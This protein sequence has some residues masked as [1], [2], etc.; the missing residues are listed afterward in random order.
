MVKRFTIGLN[1]FFNN[2]SNSG[3]VNYIFNIVAALKTLPEEE[4]PGLVIFY[5]R[6]AP[7]DFLKKIGYPY[8]EY[9]LFNAYPKKPILRKFNNLT[10]R[11]LKKDLYKQL[12]YFNKIDCLYPYFDF[13]DFEFADF[14]KKVHWLVDFNNR[15]FSAHYEDGGLFMLKSQQKLTSSKERVV[16]SSNTLLNELKQ[17]YPHYRCDVKVMRFASSL[18]VLNSRD[19]DLVKNKY[20]IDVPYLMSPNQLWEHKNQALVLDALNVLKQEHPELKFKVFF[21]GSLEVN[22]GKGLYIDLLKSKVAEYQ[23]NEYVV[24]LGVLDRQ[25]QLLL[26]Q[27]ASA[28]LQPSLYEGW[29]T[30]VEE[31]KA[32]NKFIILS[33]LP[34]HREQIGDNVAFFDPF[35]AGDLATKIEAQLKSPAAVLPIDYK[36]NI[37]K[38]GRDILNALAVTAK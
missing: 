1:Y 11:I 10:K 28:L 25:E 6:E 38:Y 21:S 30:L 31:A 12:R 9:V 29:S 13:Q 35:N 33:D 36:E 37:K 2:Q 5:G 8:I 3:I 23:L 4:K 27:G 17:Y 15:A 26:M 19:V 20:Q 32:L 14:N 18:P 24:F 34:V 7:I 16:L 22:R